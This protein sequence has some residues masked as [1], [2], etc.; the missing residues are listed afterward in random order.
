[1]DTAYRGIVVTIEDSGVVSLFG[2]EDGV[3]L[4]EMRDLIGTDIVTVVSLKNNID[5]WVDD[6]GLLKSGNFV[7]RYAIEDFQINLAVNAILLGNDGNGGTVGLNKEQITHL[8]KNLKF[9]LVGF[10]R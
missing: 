9:G 4:S 2:N 7:N 3:H 6:E 1:M 10:T 8:V 5:M